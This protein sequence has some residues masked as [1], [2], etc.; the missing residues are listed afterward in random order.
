METN[1]KPASIVVIVLSSPVAT[2]W[3]GG[4]MQ[5]AMRSFGSRIADSSESRVSFNAS[6]RPKIAPI[7]II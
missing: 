7:D 6:I 4:E 5:A 3:R 2:L 1:F